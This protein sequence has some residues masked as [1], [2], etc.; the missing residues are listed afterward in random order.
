MVVLY[1][2][3]DTRFVQKISPSICIS[4]F[5]TTTKSKNK[6]DWLEQKPNFFK[7][8]IACPRKHH[9]GMGVIPDFDWNGTRK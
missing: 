3:D 5:L 9:I 4:T 6:G 2:N 7:K 1:R 8:N